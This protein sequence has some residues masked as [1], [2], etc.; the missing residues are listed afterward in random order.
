ML[1][2]RRISYP[3]CF[4]G[5]TM[6]VL[7]CAK[8]EAMATNTDIDVPHVLFGI[9]AYEKAHPTGVFRC[10][11]TQSD[12]IDDRIS[13]LA[14]KYYS[15]RTKKKLDVTTNLYNGLCWSI[16][17]T[18][19]QGLSTVPLTLL[20][21]AMLESH[22]DI[23]NHFLNYSGLTFTQLRH[24]I[25]TALHVDRAL[26]TP[27]PIEAIPLYPKRLLEIPTYFLGEEAFLNKG[28][29]TTLFDVID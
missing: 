6:A 14:R 7:S 3:E 8:R 10:F 13:D 18:R 23:A 1:P 24:L 27:S 22:E 15:R 11:P 26:L 29:F 20:F 16:E 5:E 19:R 12:S 17:L 9:V 28:F 2:T 21:L 25:A 4:S